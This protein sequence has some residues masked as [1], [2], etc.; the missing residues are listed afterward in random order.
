MAKPRKHPWRNTIVALAVLAPIVTVVVYSSF[1]VSDYECAVCIRFGDRD[2]CRTVTGQTEE[3]AMRS[4]IN[5]ACALLAG[6]VTDT[7]RCEGTPPTSAQCRRLI[8]T[9]SDRPTMG[10][11]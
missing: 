9:P 10:P 3:E 7:I 11:A 2:A 1:Q 5:N 6:G 4:A 8:D